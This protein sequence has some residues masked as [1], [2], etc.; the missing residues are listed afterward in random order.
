MATH[1]V[2]D[3]GDCVG[4]RRLL[5][6]AQLVF[7]E[8]LDDGYSSPC[9]VVNDAVAHSQRLQQTTIDSPRLVECDSQ[10]VAS[11]ECKLI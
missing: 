5:C 6:Q 2:L 3:E 10:A 11:F 4:G 1:V 8:S 9:S 7:C